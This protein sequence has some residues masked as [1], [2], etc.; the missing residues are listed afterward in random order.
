LGW[1]TKIWRVCCSNIILAPYWLVIDIDTSLTLQILDADGTQ[2]RL[3]NTFMIFV[4]RRCPQ[5]SAQNQSMKT[6]EIGKILSREWVSNTAGNYSWLL[7]VTGLIGTVMQAPQRGCKPF[8]R[9]LTLNLV[10]LP[11][12]LASEKDVVI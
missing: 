5:V 3:M 8:M 4:W 6:G 12:D 2:K 9:T 10:I 7:S 1:T 11:K